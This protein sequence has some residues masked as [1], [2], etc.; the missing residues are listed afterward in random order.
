M[1]V[2]AGGRSGTTRLI[3]AGSAAA[4][5]FAGADE[6][7]D[8]PAP[9]GDDGP[10]CLGFGALTQKD[11]SDATQIGPIIMIA[12][13]AGTLLGPR[14]DVLGLGDEGATVLGV[15]VRRLRFGVTLLAVLLATLGGRDRRAGRVR[16]ALRAGGRAAGRAVAARSLAHRRS[17]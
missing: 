15:N 14:L 2:S 17:A 4:L 5:A 7:D 9:A 1:A 16:R 13:A 6:P 12:L 11:L 8:D 3:L 10:L